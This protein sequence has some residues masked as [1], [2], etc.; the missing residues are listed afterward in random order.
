MQ[1]FGRRRRVPRNKVRLPNAL[2]SDNVV[3]HWLVVEFI[4][5]HVPYAAGLLINVGHDFHLFGCRCCSPIESR[6]AKI[7]DAVVDA[8]RLDAIESRLAM[9]ADDNEGCHSCWWAAE[10]AQAQ[11]RAHR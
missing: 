2:E 5:G 8:G 3:T 10:H 4:D 1:F 7:D 11:S 9:I 6:L